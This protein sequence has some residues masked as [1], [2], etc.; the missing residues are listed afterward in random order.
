MKWESF[1]DQG[2]AINSLLLCRE[3]AVVSP[4]AAT[5][6]GKV[7]PQDA[8]FSPGHSSTQ[9]SYFL[10]WNTHVLANSMDTVQLLKYWPLIPKLT[11]IS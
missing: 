7:K 9:L 2:V 11:K 3:A 6:V 10:I 1:A 4:A 8:R 5:F